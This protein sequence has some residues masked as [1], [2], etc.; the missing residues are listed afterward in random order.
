MSTIEDLKEELEHMEDRTQWHAC[1]QERV[2]ELRDKVEAAEK[3][4]A[5]SEEEKADNEVQHEH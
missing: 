4:R 5:L 1:H 2:K 3:G